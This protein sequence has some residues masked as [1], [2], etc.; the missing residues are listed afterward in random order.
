MFDWWLLPR[1]KT[2]VQSK[3][4]NPATKKSFF[5]LE[6]NCENLLKKCN[7]WKIVKPFFPLSSSLLLVFFWPTALVGIFFFVFVS[8]CTDIMVVNF[9]IMKVW[10]YVKL[11]KYN[12]YIDQH[13]LDVHIGQPWSTLVAV[14]WFGLRFLCLS[15]GPRL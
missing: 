8:Q 13:C 5:K 14:M 12:I 1:R 3:R 4:P 15:S 9:K 6:K 11:L 7:K 10:F 2:H